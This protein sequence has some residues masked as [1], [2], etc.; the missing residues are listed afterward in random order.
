MVDSLIYPVILGTDFLHKHHLRLDFTSSNVTIQYNTVDVDC[1]QPLWDATVEAKAERFA[2]AATSTSSDHDIAE[3]FSVPHHDKSI[4]YEVAPCSD[5]NI[6]EVLREYKYLKYPVP[7]LWLS[8]ISQPP[9]TQY[10]SR[11]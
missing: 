11:H 3:E 2:T 8:I 10:E 1:I 4:S 5:I 9:I 6:G 7:P